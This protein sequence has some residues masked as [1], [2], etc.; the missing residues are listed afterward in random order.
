MIET[1]ETV[2]AVGYHDFEKNLKRYENYQ[3]LSN[4]YILWYPTISLW[5]HFYDHKNKLEVNVSMRGRL[6]QRKEQQILQTRQFILEQAELS[7]NEDELKRIKIRTHTKDS[8]GRNV[9]T[10]EIFEPGK[11]DETQ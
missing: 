7:F 10:E 2:E 8:K 5:S 9:I 1:T 6:T 11:K 4:W 3:R